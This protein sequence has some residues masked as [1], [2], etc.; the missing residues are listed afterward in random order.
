MSS[1]TILYAILLCVVVVVSFHYAGK[2]RIN[3]VKL[4]YAGECLYPRNIYLTY[5]TIESIPSS[6]IRRLQSLNPTYTVIP[7]GDKECIQ[8]F[9]DHW[10]TEYAEFFKSIRDGP[11]KADFWRA[12]I[13]YTF[14]GVYVDA[15]ARFV[16]PIDSFI[17]PNTSFCTSGSK[18]IWHVN[19]LFL[20][21]QPG[22][23]LLKDCV[24]FMYDMRTT[25]YSYWGYSICHH[26]KT[27]IEKHIPNYVRN[28]SACY[29]MLDGRKAQML[30]ENPWRRTSEA[31]T[32]WHD[33]LILYNHSVGTY[34][35]NI[36]VF[37]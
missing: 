22:L 28:K 8:F 31:A 14:G 30:T 12:C 4:V 36:H 19:P 33:K 23:P 34:D 9:R 37:L 17:E 10:S 18:H 13:M 20:V 35:S 24:Q 1:A 2:Q 25:Q 5:K 3:P 11:I 32:L 6:V 21:A 15:D 29:T 27:A 16:E 26:M 7:Y